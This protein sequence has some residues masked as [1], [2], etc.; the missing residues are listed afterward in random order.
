MFATSL[1]VR[2]M[3]ETLAFG[4]IVK[5]EKNRAQ[6]Y[7][8]ACAKS[9]PLLEY[10]PILLARSRSPQHNHVQEPPRI[11]FERPVDRSGHC[12][13]TDLCP[14]SRHRAERTVGRGDSRRARSCGQAHR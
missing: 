2:L 6:S 7:T 8:S 1:T 5:A 3:E 4:L 13:H 9:Y 12:K 11:F 14:W 10:R